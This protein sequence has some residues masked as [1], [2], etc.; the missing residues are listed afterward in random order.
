[1]K[2]FDQIFKRIMTESETETVRGIENVR[3]YICVC[4]DVFEYMFL[5][6]YIHP[7]L[8]Q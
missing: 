2:K 7:N 5:N 6:K 8:C 1:M 3:P 4:V